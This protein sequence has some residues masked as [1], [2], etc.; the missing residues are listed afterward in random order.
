MRAR[1]LAAFDLDPKKK[2]LA[3]G[4]RSYLRI[5]ATVVGDDGITYESTVPT[6]LPDDADVGDK[7]EEAQMESFDEELFGEVSLI[8]DIH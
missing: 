3:F 6:N 8:V 5:V 2:E 7:M 1:S 4:A